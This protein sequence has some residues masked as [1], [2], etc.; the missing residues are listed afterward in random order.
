VYPNIAVIG[1]IK[2]RDK[3]VE[4][5]YVGNNL[6]MD[7][8]LVEASG[9]SFKGISA[10]KLRRYFSWENFKDFFKVLGG[11]RQSWKILKNFKPDVVFSKGGYVALPVV[12]AAY[13]ARI[14]VVV[15]ESDI[16]PGLANKITFRVA[17]KILLSFEKSREYLS[18]KSKKKVAITGNIVRKEI[19][20]GQ[21][22][23]GYKLTGFSGERKVLLVMGGSQGAVEINEMVED[24]I[25][26]S[27]DSVLRRVLG[28]DFKIMRNEDV[29]VVHI[30]GVGKMIEGLKKENYCGLE[31]ANENL[32]DLY[33][34]ADIIVTRG[35]AGSLAELAALDKDVIIVP[36]REASRG[37]QDVNAGYFADIM[38]WRII[39][40]DENK[41]RVVDSE[42]NL[43]LDI[44]GEKA[45]EIILKMKN[46]GK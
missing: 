25:G 31:Y 5:L 32:K 26:G 42:K 7:R 33:A 39:G 8:E 2:R 34:I 37:E 44:G 38:G 6:G 12:L 43:A 13:L 35:G 27:L 30:T 36:M 4:L 28:E 45:A 29:D 19:M 16:V 9:V 22:E 11:I 10:G 1:E 23:S 21:K 14:P 41:M 20:K 3:D 18:E 17:R 40:G 15:H 46:E 24:F